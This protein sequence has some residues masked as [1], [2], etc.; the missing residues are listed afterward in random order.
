MIS[1]NSTIMNG[2][3]ICMNIEEY[4]LK[5]ILKGIYFLCVKTTPRCEEMNL[6]IC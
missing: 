4:G 1:M 5:L 3:T 2:L 6:L